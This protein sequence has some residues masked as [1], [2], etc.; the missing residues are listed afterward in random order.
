MD[1][2][3][4]QERESEQKESDF[5]SFEGEIGEIEG[6]NKGESKK[7]RGNLEAIRP[8]QIKKGEIRNPLGA[9]KTELEKVIDRKVKIAVAKADKLMKLQSPGATR[10]VLKIAKGETIG[11][12]G[13]K[14]MRTVL[15]AN[16]TI[17]DRAGI[18]APQGN[19]GVAVQINFKERGD[20]FE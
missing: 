10:R 11:E 18:V 9:R 12:Y 16:E 15:A 5:E 20:E 19:V 6:G 4:Q 13:T 3:L 14:E 7:K 8:Y 17:L 2:T 1:E